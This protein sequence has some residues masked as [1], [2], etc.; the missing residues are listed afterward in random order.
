MR[1]TANQRIWLRSPCPMEQ[2]LE[3]ALATLAARAEDFVLHNASGATNTPHPAAQSAV[4]ALETGRVM[5]SRTAEVDGGEAT[6]YACQAAACREQECPI[7]QDMMGDGQEYMRMPCSHAFHAGCLGRWL[8]RQHTC[9]MC[10]HE[11]PVEPSVN[12]LPAGVRLLPRA[13]AFCDVTGRMLDYGNDWYHRV[14]EV[15]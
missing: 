3:D 6:E 11:L 5:G 1:T 8:S 15:R 7:C 12:Q 13:R 4:A 10:R 14:G 9:P 2:L